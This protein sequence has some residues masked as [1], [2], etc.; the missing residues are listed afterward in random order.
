MCR[1]RVGKGI[2]HLESGLLKKILNYKA[3][4]QSRAR[5]RKATQ[6]VG[7]TSRHKQHHARIEKDG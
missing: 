6:A 4:E 7:Y 5:K 3:T 2:R 1:I